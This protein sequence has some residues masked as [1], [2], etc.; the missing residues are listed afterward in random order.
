[1]EEKKNKLDTDQIGKLIVSL[2]IPTVIAQLINMLYN[3]VDRMY[4][5]RMP[6]GEGALALAGLGVTFPVIMLISA[7]AALIGQGGAPRAA[8]WMG[9][10]N[11]GEAEKILGNS[12][13]FLIGMSLILTVF[14]LITKDRIL[15]MFGASQ[16]T[17]KY[18]SEYLGIYLIGTVAVQISLGLNMFISAQGFAKVSML[19]VLIGA[20]LNIVLDPILIF[21][22]SMGVKGAAIATVIS[23]IVSAV[24]VLAFLFGKKTIIRIRKECMKLDWKVIGSILVLGI[25]PFIMQSTESL[26]QLTFNS[27]MA[28][29]GNDS[30]VGAMAIIFS[31]TQF[32]NM[33]ILGLT[34]GAQPILSYNYGAKRIDRVKKAF[35]IILAMTVTISTVM[36][37]LCMI[38]P[39]MFI[40]MF[41][42]DSEL[43]R[44]GVHGLRIYMS[45]SF[46]WGVQNACQTTFLALG[47]AKISMFLALL[48]KIILLI[49]LAL[50]LP[51]VNGLGTDGLFLAEAIADII[52]VAT[53]AT[54]FRLKIKKIYERV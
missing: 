42:S 45:A 39:Q 6:G 33:P 32:V 46:L 50:I 44:V 16:N 2:A 10:K 25:S 30:Y 14:F 26:V 12:F 35:K 29:Y 8:I 38:C 27:G 21:G 43:V 18:A 13:I 24:W 20:V 41:N 1:M 19:T 15:L 17:L 5:G 40:Y 47:E 7:F 11:N 53:T 4:V 3:I 52:A 54:M 28:K 23:Q 34:Q 37:A 49:P 48:R 31:I 9:K 36:W 51:E 22:F